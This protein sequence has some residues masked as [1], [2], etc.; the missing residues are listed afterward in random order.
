MAQ[1]SPHFPSVQIEQVFIPE[2]GH[3]AHELVTQVRPSSQR[4]LIFKLD[5]IVGNLVKRIEV[6][7]WYV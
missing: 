6:L 3:F 4:D 2:E 5:Q 7:V 1:A